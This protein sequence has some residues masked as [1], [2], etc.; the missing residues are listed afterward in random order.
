MSLFFSLFFISFTSYNVFAKIDSLSNSPEESTFLSAES[1]Q[2]EN[3][4]PNQKTILFG[5]NLSAT[6]QTLK[7]NTWSIGNYVLVYGITDNLTLA[8]SPWMLNSY[9]M[10][11]AVLRYRKPLSENKDFGVQ[12]SYF[13][14]EQILSDFYQM[15][16]LSLSGIYHYKF[17]FLFSTYL[18][19]NYMYF[20]DETAPFSLRPEPYNDQAWQYSVSLLNEVKLYKKFGTLFEFGI[21]GLNAGKSRAHLGVSFH[22][23]GEQWLFQL[24]SSFSAIPIGIEKAYTQKQAKALSEDPSGDQFMVHPEIQIQYFF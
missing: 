11:S 18:N 12:I 19:F 16:A 3:N 4:T 2:I 22:Y 20:W 24:G 5:H 1:L 7:K 13:K 14:T 23:R 21:L 10:Y 17:N 6:T 9:N 8:T 15:E